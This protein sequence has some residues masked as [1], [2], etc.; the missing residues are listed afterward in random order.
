M[1]INKLITL[2]LLLFF[3]AYATA[4]IVGVGQIGQKFVYKIDKV[5]VSLSVGDVVDGC[6]VKSAGGLQCDYANNKV[7]NTN[8]LRNLTKEIANVDKWIVLTQDLQKQLKYKSDELLQLK[9]KTAGIIQGKNRKIEHLI[10]NLN[11]R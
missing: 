8:A 7:D 10:S 9:Q 5:L 2:M 11:K 1:K 3:S 6:V 4:A